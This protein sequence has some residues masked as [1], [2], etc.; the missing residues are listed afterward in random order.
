MIFSEFKNI[1]V[2]DEIR[3]QYDPLARHVRSHITLVF[4][5][6]SNLSTLEIE[7][8][9]KEALKNIKPFKLTLKMS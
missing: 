7:T 1:N 8:H 4:T 6:D 3:Y 5:F 9:L 2:I